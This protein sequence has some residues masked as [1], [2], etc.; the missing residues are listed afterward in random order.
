MQKYITA[1][2]LSY[3]YANSIKPIFSD[4]SFQLEQGW[5]GV[6]GANGSGKTTLLKLLCGLLPPDN[7]SV[8][9]K[10]PV[11]Y[12]EQRTDIAPDAFS[13]FLHA[14]D[15]SS[16][17][18]QEAL[19]IE[20]DW[21]NRWP[22]LSH[23]ERKRAQIATALFKNPLLL[24]VDEPSNHLDYNSKKIL[25]KA[26]I[27]FRGIGLL[28][29]HDRDLLDGLCN[30]TLFIHPPRID[31]RK[32]GYSIAADEIEREKQYQQVSYDLAKREV[33]KLKRKVAQQKEKATL[34]DKKRSKRT[35]NK[36]DHDAKAKKDLARLTGKDSVDGRLHK[37]LKSQLQKA[38][39][40]KEKLSY[41]KNRTLGI[42][43]DTQT[44]MLK[45]P[46]IIHKS[47]IHL[48]KEKQVV[49]PELI[50]DS[51][52]KIGIIGKNG[53]GKSTFIEYIITYF[54]LNRDQIVYIPQE[55]P[56]SF[57]EILVS[58]TKEYDGLLKGRLLNIISRLGSDPVHLLQTSLP[59]PGEV[60]KLLLAEGIMKNAGLI[61]MD[62]PTNHMD[63]P[64]IACVETA[65]K[66]CNCAQLL[67]S[68][69]YTFLNNV[70]AYYWYF[71]EEDEGRYSI[72]ILSSL[73][74]LR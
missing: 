44:S 32:N 26:L 4:I 52:A 27:S 67:V 34:S 60:R 24:A 72:E 8:D 57:S 66:E 50:I 12:C 17:R 15:K 10:G 47:K 54:S 35:L 20:D 71:K 30:H 7:G 69:D 33:K 56:I 21:I 49:F 53:T 31:L 48:G 6:V 3:T 16:Y 37:Q 45:F 36:K 43:F 25:F 38:E 46:L 11:Y 70:V 14:V 9:I 64:S 13:D 40:K 59:T 62:E 19:Q 23:G 63:L 29:S 74:S 5:T 41:I 28:V 61:I 65:L 68:H 42:T 55:I 39:G 73:A 18:L 22:S 58:R 1:D 51:A 2:T